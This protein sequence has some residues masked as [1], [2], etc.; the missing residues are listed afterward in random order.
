MEGS[1]SQFKYSGLTPL[2]FRD[3]YEPHMEFLQP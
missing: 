3:C 1:T 2:R